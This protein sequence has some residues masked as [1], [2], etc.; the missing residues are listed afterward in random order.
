MRASPRAGSTRQLAFAGSGNALRNLIKGGDGND[1]LDGGKGA[2]TLTGG[3]GDDVY[4]VN[5]AASSYV[6]AGGNLIPVPSDSVAVELAGQGNDSIRTNLASY[7]LAA[8]VN[9]EN[10]E[11]LD[12]SLVKAFVA[13]GNGLGNRISGGAGAD[14]LS[15]GLG[16]DTLA[17][18]EGSDRLSGGADADR[19]LGGA[20]DDTLDGGAGLLDVAV[21]NGTWQ[22]YQIMLLAGGTVQ[23]RSVTGSVPAT[24][25]LIGIEQVVFDQ[26]TATTVDDV[27]MEVSALQ[28]GL[29]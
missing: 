14:V 24:D 21:M 13:S 7:S 3:L 15:G 23:M 6:D 16:N 26:G 12:T 2:D 25:K 5:I 8:L 4:V 29:F 22:D 10:L 11:R 9:V 17:G 27:T 28:G 20:G 19:L 1:T 18:G